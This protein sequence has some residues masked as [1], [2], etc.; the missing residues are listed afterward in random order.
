MTKPWEM[1]GWVVVVPFLVAGC[2]SPF[3][4]DLPGRLPLLAVHVAGGGDAGWL[5]VGAASA[6]ITPSGQ[7]YLAGFSIN[8]TSQGVRDDLWCRVVVLERG[9]LRLALVALDLIGIQGDDVERLRQAVSRR[10]APENLVIHCT[11]NHHGPDTLGLWGIPP[12]ISGRD[13]GYMEE[14]ARV[15]AATLDRA[16]A[17][18]RRAEVLA[19]SGVLDPRGLARNLRRPGLLDRE[20]SVLH[21]RER[22]GGDTI[23]TLLN[24]GCHPEALWRRQRQISSD[25]PGHA[26]AEVERRLGGTALF[27]SGALGAMVTPDRKQGARDD[28]DLADAECRRIGTRLGREAVAL[29]DAATAAGSANRYDPQPR[30]TRLAITV[31]IPMDNIYLRLARVLGLIDRDFYDD[32]VVLSDLQLLRIGEAALVSV[33]GELVPDLGLSIKSRLADLGP[34]SVPFLLGLSNDELGY[35]LSPDDYSLEIFDYERT[36]CPSPRAGATVVETHAM[37]ARVAAQLE[38]GEGGL[39][40]EGLGAR[41]TPLGALGEERSFEVAPAPPAAPPDKGKGANR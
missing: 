37:L 9:G 36:L 33:P 6:P 8:R 23:A 3:E 41:G 39:G 11:H 25:F 7:V 13:E 20:L 4:R 30:L 32:G 29:I 31:P 27:F 26:R 21:L 40:R 22:G 28:P 16:L 35:L 17:S 19:V 38:R 12:F 15:V 5:R 24:F 1:W 34:D 14:L 10:V 18:M 2:A